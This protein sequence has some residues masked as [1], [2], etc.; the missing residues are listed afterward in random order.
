MSGRQ[1]PIRSKSRRAACPQ[2]GRSVACH[3]H[4]DLGVWLLRPHN[5]SKGQPCHGWKAPGS[6]LELRPGEVHRGR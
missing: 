2:C 6:A 4:W 3:Y 1:R 5:L